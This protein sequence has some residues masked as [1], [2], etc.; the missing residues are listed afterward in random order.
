MTSITCDLIIPR[1][2]VRKPLSGRCERPLGR[3]NG[4]SLC[5]TCGCRMSCFR[6]RCLCSV[7]STSTMD[8]L[9][10]SCFNADVV[11]DRSGFAARRRVSYD[12]T[13]GKIF[14]MHRLASYC[15]TIRSKTLI[16]HTCEM[17]CLPEARKHARAKFGNAQDA[18]LS[19]CDAQTVKVTLVDSSKGTR[20][21]LHDA[22][23]RRVTA[24]TNF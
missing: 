19:A 1:F 24:E 8:V 6:F 20:S 4:S 18:S 3:K 9:A 10:T 17:I 5:A 23:Q 12:R 16:S 22:Y 21:E 7:G 15:I 2:I 13:R 14:Q 11:I